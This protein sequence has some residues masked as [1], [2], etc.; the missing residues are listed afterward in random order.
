[1]RPAV[2]HITAGKSQGVRALNTIVLVL[3]GSLVMAG[4]SWVEVP[5]I[6]VPMNMQSLAAPLLGIVM[7]SRVGS[8]AVIA[9]LVEACV[10]LPVLSGGAAGAHHLLGP[11]GGYLFAFPIAAFSCGLLWE[12]LSHGSFVPSFGVM[13]LGNAIILGMG[14]AW[15]STI[16]GWQAGLESGLYP[17][18]LGAVMK[19]LL[20][21]GAVSLSRR[22][23]PE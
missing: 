14:V 10:G 12:R 8:L 18:L 1:M 15:L 19:S 6:P 20:G 3:L 4:S 23:L 11:T 7:G 21:A 22:R 13:L 9:W 16:I 2:A 17:F 5:M